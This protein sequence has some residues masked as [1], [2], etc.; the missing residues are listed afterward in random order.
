[1]CCAEVFSP[2]GLCDC[3]LAIFCDTSGCLPSG[4]RWHFQWRAQYVLSLGH[5]LVL[6]FCSYEV[7]DFVAAVKFRFCGWCNDFVMCLCVTFLSNPSLWLVLAS[8]RGLAEGSTSSSHLYKCNTQEVWGVGLRDTASS[9]C[10]VSNVVWCVRCGVLW[11]HLIWYDVWCT[12]GCD[13]EFNLWCD[14]WCVMQYAM[15]AYN[16][17]QLRYIGSLSTNLLCCINPTEPLPR[18]ACSHSTGIPPSDCL[19]KV[20]KS[21]IT[22]FL[23][24]HFGLGCLITSAV[25]WCFMFQKGERRLPSVQTSY[26]KKGVALGYDMISYIYINN[27]KLQHFAAKGTDTHS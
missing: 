4:M 1:M 8:A 10:D 14:V 25:S 24:F 11:C 2:C 17:S 5:M 16:H 12:M 15:W 20:V 9:V 23:I 18:V 22:L 3:F 21:S 7:I 13:V 27:N 19:I 26:H 6:K